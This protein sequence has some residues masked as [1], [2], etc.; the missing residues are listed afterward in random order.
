VVDNDPRKG[1]ELGEGLLEVLARKW[2]GWGIS[3]GTVWKNTMGK[4]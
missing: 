1:E 2:K 3:V 4:K